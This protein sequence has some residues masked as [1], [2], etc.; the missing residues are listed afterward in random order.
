[1]WI[2]WLEP[3]HVVKKSIV[4]F[5]WLY[6]WKYVSADLGNDVTLQIQ[7]III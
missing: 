5:S 7:H 3:L 1:M 6:K 2:L 4:T